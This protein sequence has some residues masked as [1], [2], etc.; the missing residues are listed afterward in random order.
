MRQRKEVEQNKIRGD[1]GRR[2]HAPQQRHGAD[3][4]HRRRDHMQE[5]IDDILVMPQEQLS[6]LVEKVGAAGHLGGP[7]RGCSRRVVS[8]LL[9]YAHK[10]CPTPVL[11]AQTW[12]R[13]YTS[14]WAWAKK[15]K[16]LTPQASNNRIRNTG[17]SNRRF[18]TRALSQWQRGRR[19]SSR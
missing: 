2:S 9:P 4:T 11:S 15:A 17:G 7:K 18:R 12:G 10:S 16:N 13:K 1:L 5:D 19:S 14:V 3:E 8:H 6:L